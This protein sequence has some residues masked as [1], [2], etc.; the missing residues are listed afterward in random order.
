MNSCAFESGRKAFSRM[1]RAQ[2]QEK[3]YSPCFATENPKIQS[4]SPIH[5]YI[6]I[7]IDR[8]IAPKAPLRKA[9][10]FGALADGAWPD[11]LRGQSCSRS[12]RPSAVAAQRCLWSGLVVKLGAPCK[13]LLTSGI[14]QLNA[15]VESWESCLED[16]HRLRCAADASK[17]LPKR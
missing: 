14:P 3:L 6:Y 15:S 9:S 17:A 13:R 1:H 10:S 16:P 4:V 8:D 11:G 12:R 2:V 5:I 7:E